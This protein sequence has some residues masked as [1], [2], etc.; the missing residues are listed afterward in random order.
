[1]LDDYGANFGFG[2]ESAGDERLPPVAPHASPAANLLNVVMHGVT[3]HHRVSEASLV[4][5]HE[6]DERWLFNL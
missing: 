3:G 4:D 5:G 2:D 1:M 6:I